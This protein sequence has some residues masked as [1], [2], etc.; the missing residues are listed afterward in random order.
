[1]AWLVPL[2][3][4]YYDP[5]YRYQLE[6]KAEKVVFRGEWAEVAEWVKAQ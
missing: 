5:M 4:E 2:L 3:E 6:K 1:L